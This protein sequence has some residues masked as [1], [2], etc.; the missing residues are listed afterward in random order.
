MTTTIET[1]FS[2][3]END[4]ESDDNDSAGSV[5]QNNDDG[6]G[7]NVQTQAAF[8]VEQ[9]HVF[10]VSILSNLKQV[11]FGTFAFWFN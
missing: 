1:A 9:L 6:D 11:E 3:D 4:W 10:A 5:D 2:S 8:T 7:N